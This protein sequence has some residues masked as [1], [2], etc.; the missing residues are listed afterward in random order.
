MQKAPGGRR[1]HAQEVCSMIYLAK[2]LPILQ[3]GTLHQ[4][5]Q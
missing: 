3:V 1:I 4:A 2:K 5:V